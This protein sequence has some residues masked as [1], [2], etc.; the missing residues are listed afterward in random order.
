VKAL[1]EVDVIGDAK[2]RVLLSGKPI[3]GLA[4]QGPLICACFGV[5]FN[6]IRSAIQSGKAASVEDIGKALRAGTNCG[7]CLPELKKIVSSEGMRKPPHEIKPRP[8]DISIAASSDIIE[9][10]NYVR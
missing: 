3:D 2:R 9:K 5:G 1:F 10:I 7:S 4:E 6:V 8:D